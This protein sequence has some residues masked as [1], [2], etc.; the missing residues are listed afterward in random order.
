[1][2]LDK[3][4]FNTCENKSKQTDQLINVDLK[5]FD[6]LECLNIWVQSDGWDTSLPFVATF[7]LSLVFS[8]PL[9]VQGIKKITYFCFKLLP[10]I[11]FLCH[12]FW[13]FF[14]RKVSKLVFFGVYD[15]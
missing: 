12:I 9:E 5:R 4:M 1:M 15:T 6:S 14:D 10:N 11:R 13:L 7:V 3:D 2:T 8:S